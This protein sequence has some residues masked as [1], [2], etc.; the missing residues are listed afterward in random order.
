MMILLA[1]LALLGPGDET[2]QP[3]GSNHHASDVPRKHLEEIV[4]AKHPYT[5]TQGG[6]MDGRSCRSPLGVGMSREGAMEQT[7]ESNRA[8]R[9]ENVGD[10]DVV[11]PW[12][13]NGKN[14]YRS[15]EEI[16]TSL[17]SPGMTD[18]EKATSIW[19]QWTRHQYHFGGGE[20]PDEADLVRVF[21]IYGYNSCGHDS[22]CL[23]ALWKAARLKPA[24]AHGV[25][26]CIP[27]VFYDGRWHLYDGD[28][29]AFY[30]LRDNETV[31]GEPD[32]ARD[33]DLIKRTHTLGL[34]Q[35]ETPANE[36][37]E[38]AMYGYEAEPN[39]DRDGYKEGSMKMVLRPGEALVWRWGHLTPVK[40]YGGNRQQLYPDTV[41][42]GLWEYRP[43]F[44]KELWRKG[45]ASVEGVKATPDGL[46]AEDGKTGTIVW[47]VQS[48]YVLV[49]G[50]LT[51]EGSGAEFSL[52][53]DGKAWQPV[54][55]N[56]DPSF[57]H[58]QGVPGRHKYFLRCSLQGQARLKSLAIANDLQMAPLS[59]PEMGIGPNAFAYTDE[60]PGARKVRI[61]HEWVERSASKPPAAPVV[62][63]PPDSGESEGTD[64]VFRWTPPSD[65]DGD[66]IVDYQFE[67]CNRPDM[68]WPLSMSF[69]KLISRTSDKGKAQYTLPVPGLLTA[70]RKYYWHV[71]AKDAKGVW[72]AWSKTWTFTPRGPNY[73]LDAVV[74]GDPS[75]GSPVLRWKANATGAPAVAYR[76][77]GSDEKGFSVSDGP[78]EV[79]VG[80][81]KEVTSPFQANFLGETKGTEFRLL[82]EGADAARPVRAYYRVVAVDAKGKRSGSS[83]CA[84]A[85]RPIVYSRPPEKAKVGAPYKYAILA[86][87][88]IGDLKFRQVNG[89]DTAKYWDVEKF[90]FAVVKAPE[91]LKLDADTGVLQGTPPAAGAVEVEVSLVLEREARK[92]DP[93]TLAWG[94][95]KVVS[96]GTEKSGT[97]AHRFTIAVEP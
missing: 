6:T 11:N 40:Y 90:K 45:A 80:E 76:I 89:R 49:G 73:P 60:N 37:Y 43:D 66:A 36:Q 96:T 74:D 7:W 3:W 92:L 10:T 97:A 24:P 28:L 83:D 82:G 32:I 1:I 16:V 21:N 87:R 15:I 64:V 81:S 59:L 91:W 20:A 39:G 72:G 33:H 4:E 50:R 13:S 67:L 5:V 69:Y 27:Q 29:H 22:M 19:F 34:L 85:P 63:Y 53:W 71:R 35:P 51:T 44:G 38:A 95:E 25:G 17:T 93:G 61:T 8:V 14:G 52:S 68:K 47:V 30:L 9:L 41:C 18:Q 54:G 75:K 12:L 48:P 79:V 23:S 42:N 57:A 70:A 46:A 56:L 26:H 86:N 94:N 55:E 78:Y 58:K 84:V 88:S 62:V 31:A 2:L 65:A 77:Y